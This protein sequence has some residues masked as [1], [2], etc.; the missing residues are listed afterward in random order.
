MYTRCFPWYRDYKVEEIDKL[1][2][3]DINAPFR[4]TIYGALF[5]KY[6]SP[7]S[8]MYE[9]VLTHHFS[10]KY[11]KSRNMEIISKEGLLL[12]FC[13]YIER[14]YSIKKEAAKELIKMSGEYYTEENI[15]LFLKADR[16]YSILEKLLDDSYEEELYGFFEKDFN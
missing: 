7:L 5:I 3:I 15:K 6:F 13:D 16:E 10:D 8:K 1:A 14:I 12:N 9:I 11:Y 4:R 2:E